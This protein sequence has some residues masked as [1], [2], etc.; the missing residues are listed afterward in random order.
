MDTI[1]R[2]RRR[3]PEERPGQI[4]DAAFVEFGQRGLAGA[5][6]DD[7]AKRAGVGKGTIY[8]YFE[9][10]EALFREMVR[11]TLGA[12]IEESEQMMSSHTSGSIESLFRD[13]ASKWWGFIRDERFA[14]VQRLVLAG[15]LRDFPELM[16][17]FATDIIARGR[18]VVATIIA[19]GIESGEFRPTDPAIAARMYSAIWFAHANWA[20][21]THFHPQMGS[22]PQVLEEMLDFF[23]R[24]IKQ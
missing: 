4:L 17:F 11:V 13:Y 5:R 23:L 12:A 24:A 15:E 1:E 18:R 7:I 6:L 8:L 2:S 9:T 19:R 3:C 22:D 16:A 21:N 20:A 10:K 14:V